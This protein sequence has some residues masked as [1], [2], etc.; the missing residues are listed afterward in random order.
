MRIM[1]EWSDIVIELFCSKCGIHV[2]HKEAG[3]FIKEG[4]RHFGD[5]EYCPK[6]SKT[7]NS[8]DTEKYSMA[9][10]LLS[11]LS[12]EIERLQKAE[13]LLSKAD[14]IINVNW[15]C[16]MTVSEKNKIGKK[17]RKYFTRED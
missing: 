9:L 3:K 17:I 7:V 5:V 13:R 14:D 1:N 4:W 12:T 2:R 11:N 16:I 15:E 10:Y 8:I 6:C